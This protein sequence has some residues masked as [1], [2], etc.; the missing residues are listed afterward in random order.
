MGSRTDAVSV[1][2]SRRADDWLSKR[3][4]LGC[5]GLRL[6]HLGQ[7]SAL[8]TG[9]VHK[10]MRSKLN[11]KYCEENCVSAVMVSKRCRWKGEISMEGG[12]EKLGKVSLR[13]RD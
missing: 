7:L 10:G 3:A 13:R 12:G 2:S 6:Q 11:T 4:G 5:S 1:L 8:A 9:P